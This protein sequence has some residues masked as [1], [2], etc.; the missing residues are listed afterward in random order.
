MSY[1]IDLLPYICHG[2]AY[3][4][5]ERC[6]AP[7]CHKETRV[8]VRE[9]IIG[10]M[11]HGD[12]DD[13]PKKIM[14][15]S[16]PAGAG[17]TAIAGSVA[18]MCKA[19]GTLAAS[20][21]FS[22]FSVSAD[23]RSKRCVVTTIANHL[24]EHK[25][26][27]EF[28]T[29]LLF[30]IQRNPSIFHKRLKDQ[31]ECLLLAP[32]RAIGHTSDIATWPNGII[33]D[34]LDEVEAQQYD[35]PTRRDATRKHDDDQLEILDVLFTLA[36]DPAF[37]FRICIS[38][39]PERVISEF[40]STTAQ[41][42][43]MKLFLDSKYNPDADIRLF[44]EAKF[45]NIRRRAG[46][47]SPSW[48]GV[49][50]LDRLVEMCSG[51][52]IVPVTIIRWMESGLPQRQLDAVL[53][54]DLGVDIGNKNPFATLDALYRHILKRAN[55]PDDDPHLA[56]KWIRSIH[57]GFGT[58]PVQGPFPHETLTAKFWKQFFED[59]EGELSYRLGPI[60]S[61]ISVPPPDNTSSPISIY[62][63]SLMDFLSSPTRCG[64]LYVDQPSRNSFMAE[65]FLVVLKRR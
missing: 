65:R 49:P 51:Q 22:S 62:H 42:S 57:S 58:D 27:Q 2:A 41:E 23:R 55:N 48:P 35:D 52:F 26:L 4:S 59:E 7:A 28:K 34:G 33:I 50:V 18:E 21:F 46:M 38:S 10:W 44:L 13:A 24:A 19:E 20:F 56:V 5:N 39:R 43:T 60:T 40:F 3:N 12:G 30:S 14:W 6:D 37:P 45:A 1:A 16:G 31:A 54:L 8:A 61:L 32:F 25:A 63:K 53:Q 11:R 17:K 64:D 36:A 9:E 15:L 47:S 29:Q